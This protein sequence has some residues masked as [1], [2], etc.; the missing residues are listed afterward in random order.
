MRKHEKTVEICRQGLEIN[1]HFPQFW[2]ISGLSLL[3]QGDYEDAIKRFYRS[4]KLTETR[5]SV[6]AD[7]ACWI[8][9]VGRTYAM[10]GEHDAAK[11][12][13]EETIKKTTGRDGPYFPIATLC[14]AIGDTD[15]G[16]EWLERSTEENEFWLP[17]FRTSPLF[18]SVRSDPRF[19][20]LIRRIG[21]DPDVQEIPDV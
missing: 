3:E 9:Y 17:V 4:I 14:F 21:L 15:R 5:A 8:V 1:E 20:S 12:I 16:F 2:L 7:P 13:L 6:G 11:Q 18:D 19:L 10:M